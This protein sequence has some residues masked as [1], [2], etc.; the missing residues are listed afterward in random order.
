MLLLDVIPDYLS[1]E[2]ATVI[3]SSIIGGLISGLGGAGGPVVMATLLTIVQLPPPLVAGTSSLVFMGANIAMG[4]AYL[5]SGDVDF[6]I[7]F[8]MLLPTLIGIRFGLYLNQFLSARSFSIILAVLLIVLSI[9]LLYREFRELKPIIKLDTSQLSD[10]VVLAGIGTLTGIVSGSTGFGGPGLII[11]VLLILGVSPLL[12]VGSG[13]CLG[14]F[15]TSTTAIS[16]TIAG[17]VDFALALASGIPFVF[18]GLLGWKIAHIVD[19]DSLKITIGTILLLLAP[20]VV[21]TT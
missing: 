5:Y 1:I 14:I 19:Q 18:A 12:A 2:T 20:I 11:P 3:I 4:S 9:N 8:I 6:R 10:V 21:F 7:I 13:I 17:N 16:Y 15:I